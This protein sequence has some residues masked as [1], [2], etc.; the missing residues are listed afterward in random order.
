MIACNVAQLLKG[1][2]GTV[3][4]IEVD[5]LDTDLAVEL[6]L[7]SPTRGQLRLMRTSA[8]ILVT[9]TLV[10]RIEE[11]CSR[12]LE[13]F[14]REQSIQ[15]NDEFVPVIDVV[16]GLPAA[17]PD[18]AEAFRLTPDHMLD[19][20]EAIRQYAILEDPL[21][22]LCSPDCRGLCVGCGAN[23]NLGPCGCQVAPRAAAEA[24]SFG[25][26]LAERLRQAGFKS[27]Q[28]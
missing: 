14:T 13:R 18:D 27:E 15:L 10:Q 12:C 4:R 16:T 22:P 6:H 17:E 23:L 3:R 28:E 2:T 9:G 5:E 19:L 26:L 8:G 20:N 7:V 21:Q 1:P 24:P 25:T 11:T